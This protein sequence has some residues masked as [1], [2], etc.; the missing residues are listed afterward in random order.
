MPK[1]KPGSD[2]EV[3]STSAVVDF[4]K[5]IQPTEGGLFPLTSKDL[6]AACHN[7][8]EIQ[9]ESFKVDLRFDVN[10]E[11]HRWT[12]KLFTTSLDA[13]VD[14][15]VEDVAIYLRLLQ[16]V[17]LKTDDLADNLDI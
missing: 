4:P 15:L 13:T 7:E 9:L 1:L 10:V 2:N 16:D 8:T 5:M 11:R 6:G 14:E 3:M 17:P 12:E